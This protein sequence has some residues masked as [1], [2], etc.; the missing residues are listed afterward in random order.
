M[1]WD[2]QLDAFEPLAP[3][4]PY[5]VGYLLL[6][7]FLRILVWPFVMGIVR[8][9]ALRK[10]I[11]RLLWRVAYLALGLLLLASLFWVISSL[12]MAE[13]LVDFLL[14]LGNIS[15]PRTEFSFPVYFILL[16]LAAFV[17][18][19]WFVRRPAPKPRA[20]R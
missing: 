12:G 18:L 4:L 10:F 16:A 9:G 15:I 1:D 11:L 7:L 2:V 3:I 20:R 8:R 5:L 19:W 13:P 14:G 6:L 17:G